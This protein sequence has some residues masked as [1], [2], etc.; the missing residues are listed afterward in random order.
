MM[1][2]GGM[3]VRQMGCPAD[4]I[5][6]CEANGQLR[7]L[8]IR[9]VDEQ[10]QYQKLDIEAILRRDVVRFTGAEAEQFLC[11]ATVEGTPRLFWLRYSLRNHSWCI[12]ETIY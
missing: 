6:L 1:I 9:Y 3:I 7:P 2:E 10:Q 12:T 4:V 5:S 8:R 11:R